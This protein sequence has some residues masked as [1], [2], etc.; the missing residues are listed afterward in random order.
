MFKQHLPEMFRMFAAASRTF[1]KQDES[2]VI[3]A[4]YSWIEET[5]FSSEVL[6]RSA[7]RLMVMRVSDVSW[8]DWGEPQRVVNTLNTL[9]V[10][11]KWM[12]ALAA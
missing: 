11:T 10:R 6:E 5:N 2:A 7:D 3:R 9:G 12:Q 8:S 4:I 1:G